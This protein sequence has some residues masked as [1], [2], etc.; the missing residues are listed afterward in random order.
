MTRRTAPE[1]PQEGRDE[2]DADDGDRADGCRT[3]LPAESRKTGDSRSAALGPLSTR[4]FQVVE[5]PYRSSRSSAM[6]Q[7]VGR[8][9]SSSALSVKMRAVT[10][11]SLAHENRRI[12]WLGDKSQCSQ[13]WNFKPALAAFAQ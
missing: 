2:N 4:T 11:A 1:Q 8:P 9:Q 6:I 7:L 10:A 5:F 12:R 13:S 3:P